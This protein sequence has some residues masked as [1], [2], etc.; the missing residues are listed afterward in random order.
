MRARN[1]ADR[2]CEKRTIFLNGASSRLI[3][4]R[5][6]DQ[7]TTVA[8]IWLILCLIFITCQQALFAQTVAETAQSDQADAPQ[9]N[10]NAE[11]LPAIEDDPAPEPISLPP[12]PFTGD[13]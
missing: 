3:S 11:K 8:R 9:Q 7:M 5:W 1:R 10:Q 4:R 2:K 13:L 12:N 6:E